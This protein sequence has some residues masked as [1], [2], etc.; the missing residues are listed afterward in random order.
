MSRLQKASAVKW[1]SFEKRQI[2][3][4]SYLSSA[5][6]E[7]EASWSEHAHTLVE[8]LGDCVDRTLTKSPDKGQ[9]VFLNTS[10]LHVKL[11]WS[12]VVTTTWPKSCDATS[13]FSF[14]PQCYV[15]QSQITEQRV[16]MLT[17]TCG[18]FKS[19]LEFLGLEDFLPQSKIWYLWVNRDDRILTLFIPQRGNLNIA[20]AHWIQR[21][22]GLK[23]SSG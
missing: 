23:S 12:I 19:N 16:D 22:R 21:I 4:W 17:L 20:A 13:R 2:P 3:W 11:F 8:T 14:S 9:S 10:V 6:W 7:V 5:Q 18:L 1:R 15:G